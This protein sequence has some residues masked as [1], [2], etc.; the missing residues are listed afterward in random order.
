MLFLESFKI[1]AI[2][3]ISLVIYFLNAFL[4][5]E[6]SRTPK[7][8]GIE[9][10][11]NVPIVKEVVNCNITLP[12]FRTRCENMT[13]TS[14][15]NKTPNTQPTAECEA[16]K[17]GDFPTVHKCVFCSK[18]VHL[19]E[20]CS[21]PAPGSEEG[22]SQ[23]GICMNCYSSMIDSVPTQGSQTENRTT[24]MTNKLVLS[25]NP[26]TGLKNYGNACYINSVVQSFNYTAGLAS[27][28]LAQEVDC[29]GEGP[30]VVQELKL[31]MGKLQ[32]GKKNIS[33]QKLKGVVGKYNK[34]FGSRRQQDS[35][36]FLQFLLDRIHDELKKY[37]VCNN[38]F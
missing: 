31:L 15:N 5:V 23:R 12:F 33:T 18:L 10:R 19:L 3:K 36:E 1:F 24:A 6:H 32:L 35:Q 16:C 4:P 11:R 20:G 28:L 38:L 34:M 17:R 8:G 14:S 2:A 25:Q 9:E 13:A 21:V 37:E 26:K 29:N 30:F 7:I 22:Y 27:Y